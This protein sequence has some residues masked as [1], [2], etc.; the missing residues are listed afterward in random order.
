[1]NNFEEQPFVFETITPLAQTA[2]PQKSRVMRDAHLDGQQVL[3]SAREDREQAKV[4]Y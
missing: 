3:G 2:R 4:I 1:M